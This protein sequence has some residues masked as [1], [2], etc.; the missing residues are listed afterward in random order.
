MKGEVAATNQILF[1][2]RVVTD[3]ILLTQQVWPEGLE[4]FNINLA[5][6]SDLMDMLNEV[7]GRVSTLTIDFHDVLSFYSRIIQL[8]ITWFLVIFRLLL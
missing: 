2:Q 3:N 6:K 5:T 7:R 1:S 8:F 4:D